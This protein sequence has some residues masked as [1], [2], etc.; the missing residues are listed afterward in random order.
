MRSSPRGS[1]GGLPAVH[2]CGPWPLVCCFSSPSLPE[3]SS[4]RGCSRPPS[5]AREVHGIVWIPK[6][7]VRPSEG[8]PTVARALED[9]CV[10][11]R[12]A[13]RY[14]LTCVLHLLQGR[15]PALMLR[16]GNSASV[17]DN[18]EKRARAATQVHKVAREGYRSDAGGS[19]SWA[20][21]DRTTT[22]VAGARHVE[23]PSSARNVPT[24]PRRFAPSCGPSGRLHA[25]KSWESMSL[26]SLADL[27]TVLTISLGILAMSRLCG[28]AYG[29]GASCGTALTPRA[30]PRPLMAVPAA[31]RA[32]RRQP[33]DRLLQEP[34]VR[35]SQGGAKLTA[36]AAQVRQH[37]STFALHTLE[38]PRL[39]GGVKQ[40]QNH[41]RDRSTR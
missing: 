31:E 12:S 4:S 20:G 8:L 41:V 2:R 17:F 24:E 13:E 29:H 5:T 18:E 10:P 11:F 14:E 7:C 39:R 36:R 16:A 27:G 40:Q 22:L 1:C 30:V 38:L 21:C 9:G 25:P 26:F 19:A 32:D 33:T 34:Q 15:D 6:W 37:S 28:S 23:T 35:A 3:R